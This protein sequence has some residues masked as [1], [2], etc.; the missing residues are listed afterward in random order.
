M[1]K[2]KKKTT[3]SKTTAKSGKLLIGRGK[4]YKVR[5]TQYIDAG[6]VVALMVKKDRILITP[7]EDFNPTSNC[8]M[9]TLWVNRSDLSKVS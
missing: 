9:D 1:F 3:T 6:K 8:T 2:N 4:V 7:K 5:E